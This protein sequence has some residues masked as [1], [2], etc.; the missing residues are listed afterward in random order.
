MFG[1]EEDSNPR[2]SDRRDTRGSTEMPD[3][4]N[5]A[6]A[7]VATHAA[8]IGERPVQL[9]LADRSPVAQPAERPTLNREV[10]GANP[11]G[12]AISSPHHAAS[13]AGRSLADRRTD[14]AEAGG[15][16][17]SRRTISTS[18]RSSADQSGRLRTGGSWVQ[19]LPGAPF[20]PGVAQQ[21]RH[22]AQNGASAG[23]N[24]AAGTTL[25]PVAQR[26][27]SGLKPR[28]VP[29]RIRPGALHLNARVAQQKRHR[30]QNSD[31]ASAT[32]AVGPN[33]T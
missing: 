3:H 4:F 6:K 7:L 1:H 10:D 12:A 18:S 25:A 32:L 24:P 5:S 11:S 8:G 16:E 33:G 29:V 19:F 2:R 26:R 21:Q 13:C 14:I 17:P 23:A 31:S 22:S 20:F 30:L 28:S 27:G 9:R 15:A